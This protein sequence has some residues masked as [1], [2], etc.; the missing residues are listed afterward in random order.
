[1]SISREGRHEKDYIWINCRWILNIHSS[2]V[3]KTEHFK[4]SIIIDI[5]SYGALLNMSKKMKGSI[6]LYHI[7]LFFMLSLTWMWSL[8][9][10]C[11]PGQNN[12]HWSN[13][14]VNFLYVRRLNLAC[15]YLT[16]LFFLGLN[17]GKTSNLISQLIVQIIFWV[18]QVHNFLYKAFQLFSVDKRLSWAPRDKTVGQKLLT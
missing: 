17:T 18:W 3:G 16:K 14:T 4:E 1:M 6:N 2:N 12:L 8:W 11:R 15:L 9:S 10:F 5:F 7:P 13:Q